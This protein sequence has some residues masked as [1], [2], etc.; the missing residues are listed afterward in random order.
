MYN[1]RRLLLSKETNTKH[2]PG[3]SPTPIKKEF[4]RPPLDLRPRNLEHYYDSD[5]PLAEAVGSPMQP[6]F[7]EHMTKTAAFAS[8]KV[9]PPPAFH[10]LLKESDTAAEAGTEQKTVARTKDRHAA[11]PLIIE[12]QNLRVQSHQQHMA[13]PDQRVAAKTPPT[14]RHRQQPATTAN[15]STPGHHDPSKA[16]PTTKRKSFVDAL[17]VTPSHRSDDKQLEGSET[18]FRQQEPTHR[19]AKFLN[20][21]SPKH[22]PA[23]VATKKLFHLLQQQN[24]QKEKKR[25]LQNQQENLQESNYFNTNLICFFLPLESTKNPSEKSSKDTL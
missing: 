11:V 2:I 7:R 17:G 8:G 6:P 25:K 16:T 24:L 12:W 13:T 23:T 22:S 10:E 5:E 19:T 21:T 18:R 1:E 15:T 14:T 9:P 20:F 3:D 4:V